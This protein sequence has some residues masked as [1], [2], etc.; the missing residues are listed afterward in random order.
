MYNMEKVNKNKVFGQDG[1]DGAEDGSRV[2]CS[3]KTLQFS[4]CF[5]CFFVVLHVRCC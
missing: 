5:I 1:Q 2:A 4:V 3:G